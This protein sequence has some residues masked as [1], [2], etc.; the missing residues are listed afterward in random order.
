LDEFPEDPW[1]ILLVDDDEDDYLITRDALKIAPGVSTELAWAVSYAAGLQMLAANDYDVVLVDYDLGTHTG[2]QFIRE[3]LE[4]G[5]A[6]PLILYTGR[7]SFETEIEAMEAGASFYLVKSEAAP[8][9]LKRTLRY[10]IERRRIEDE[11]DRRSQERLDILESIQDGFFSINRD[12][13]ITY[14]NRRAAQNGG[15]NALDLLGKNIWEAFPKMIGTPLEH[16][17]R[18]AMDESKTVQFETQ[19]AYLSVWYN[20]SVYP[21]VEGISVYWQ[22]ISERKRHEQ[23]DDFIARINDD[24]SRQLPPDE[25]MQS[26]GEKIVSRF[27]LTRLTFAYVDEDDDLITIIHDQHTPGLIGASGNLRIS[28]FVDADSMPKLK[29]GEVFAVDDIVAD[30]RTAPRAAVYTA[31]GIR[32]QLIVPYV[33]KDRWRFVAFLQKSEPYSWRADE[34][35]LLGRLV[36]RLYLTLERARSDDALRGSEARYRQ[37]AELSPDAILVNLNGRYIYANPAAA[38]LMGA[39]PS[40]DGEPGNIT[41]QD[42]IGRSPFEFLDP[43]YHALVRERIRHTIEHNAPTEMISY[44]WRRLD[45]SSVYV[46]VVAGPIIWQGESA[47]LVIARDVTERRRMEQALLESESRFRAMADDNPI[48]IW[49]TD[50]AGKVQFVN[51]AYTEFFGATVEQVQAGGWQSFVHPDNGD[52][53]QRFFECLRLQQ[54]FYAECRFRRHDGQWRWVLSCGQPRFSPDGVFLGM[55]GSSFEKQ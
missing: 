25:M 16:A 52:A 6:V 13:E 39:R 10:A 33:S 17:Y 5:C 40:D 23:D 45:G 55:A 4:R 46:E 51:R 34:I 50:A 38:R 32:A 24:F 14:I 9:L 1:R 31:F 20:I 11:L 12:W 53:I 18:Q 48:L 21:S 43:E 28:E 47:T 36:P 7:G 29:T 19:G 54:P 8:R 30:P 26:V 49:I 2:V 15:Y 3:T 42:L 44:P 37:L 22:D 41:P 27:S 35:Y